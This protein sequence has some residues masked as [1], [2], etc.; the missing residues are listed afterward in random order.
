MFIQVN[1]S[2]P[3]T[4]KEYI[5]IFHIVRVYPINIPHQGPKT[6][7]VLTEPGNHSPITVDHSYDNVCEMIDELL[8]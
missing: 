5:N 8:S 7:I 1:L 6:G 2:E 4:G 3:L